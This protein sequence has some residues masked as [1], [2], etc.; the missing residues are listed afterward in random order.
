[1]GDGS[2]TGLKKEILHFVLN[3]TTQKNSKHSTLNIEP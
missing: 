2:F 3:D 1:M